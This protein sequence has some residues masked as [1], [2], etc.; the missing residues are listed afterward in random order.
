MTPTSRRA[1]RDPRRLARGFARLATDRATVAVFAVLAA[2]WAVGFFGV[3]P[4]EIWFVDFPAL[5]AAFF[6]DTLAANEFGVRETATF[7]PAL[8]V[9]GYLQAMLVVAVVRVLRTRLAG[10]GE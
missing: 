6:F 7:Y 4:K 1:A 2:A 10:V 3:L 5:V 8:A 9:F